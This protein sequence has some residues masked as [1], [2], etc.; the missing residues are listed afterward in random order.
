ML[1]G[2]VQGWSVRVCVCVCGGVMV[3]GLLASLRSRLKSD[4]FGLGGGG[5]EINQKTSGDITILTFN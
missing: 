1:G 2:G 3:L 5:G 4:P